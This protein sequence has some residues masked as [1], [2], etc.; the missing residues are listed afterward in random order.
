MQTSLLLSFLL[1]LKW[2]NLTCGETYVAKC[3]GPGAQFPAVPQARQEFKSS[4]CHHVSH[5]A[6]VG[7]SGAKPA[8]NKKPVGAYAFD[9]LRCDLRATGAFEECICASL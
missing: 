5:G 3:H 9:L 4:L 8:L 7:L 6:C 1:L 2:G